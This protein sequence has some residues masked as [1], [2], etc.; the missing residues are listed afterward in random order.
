MEVERGGLLA[1]PTPIVHHQDALDPEVLQGVARYV[2][3]LEGRV[4]SKPRSCVNG[5][6]SRSDLFEHEF[7]GKEAL[8]RAINGALRDAFRLNSVTLTQSATVHLEGWANVLRHGGYHKPHRH[9]GSPWSGVVYLQCLSGSDDA[10][11]VEFQDPRLGLDAPSPAFA[12]VGINL[13]IRPAAGSVV[14]FPSWLTHFVNP[15]KGEEPRVS[16]AFN[17]KNVR[18]EGRVER[19]RRAGAT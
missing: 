17:V 18:F 3:S 14:V 19:D 13:K 6:Q 11:V 16:V 15:H 9:P 8:M 1:F 10:G 12:N 4:T 7:V 5:W 2:L